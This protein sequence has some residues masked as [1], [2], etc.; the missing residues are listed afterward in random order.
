MV[1]EQ[2]G[3][4]CDHKWGDGPG[5]YTKLLTLAEG[6]DAR[7]HALTMIGPPLP[8]TLTLADGYDAHNHWIVSRCTNCWQYILT[9]NGE[10]KAAVVV[11]R[12]SATSQ[13]LA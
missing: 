1:T 9:V 12:K 10:S 3:S 6:Y 13:E 5:E 11:G 8:P 7:N 4:T 2:T